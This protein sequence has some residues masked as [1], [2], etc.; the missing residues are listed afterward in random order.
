[1][2]D[3]ARTR[4][5]RRHL[6]RPA[7]LQRG[8]EPRPASP[9]PSWTPLP[10]ATLLVV[11]DASPDGTGELADALA[12]DEPRVRVLHRAAQGGPRQGLYRRLPRRRSRRGAGR[13]VQMD[14]DWSHSP[15]YLP[16]LDGSA[17]DD[18]ADLVIGSRYTRGRRRPRL[19]PAAPRSSRA[20]ARS[21]RASCC[22]L[23]PHDLT[24][25]FKAW[26]ARRSRRS[27]GSA[28]TPAATSSRSR[29]R[30][31]PARRGARGGGAHRLR[32]PRRWAEQDVPLDHPGG[33][34]GRAAAALG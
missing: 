10:G 13:I 20:A 22:G 21:S 30:T 2:T 16:A 19:G 15:D 8:G 29:R 18:G 25:G 33:A 31:S 24:G 26:R 12:A 11:D 4:H 3:A 34:R 14:A 27:T 1:M 9:R 28:S 5:L 17:L 23:R 7:H 6:G 32:G